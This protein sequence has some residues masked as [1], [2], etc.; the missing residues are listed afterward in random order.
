MNV[1][2]NPLLGVFVFPAVIAF[3][4]LTILKHSTREKPMNI[5]KNLSISLGYT[6]LFLIVG[7]IMAW[8]AIEVYLYVGGFFHH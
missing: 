7:W 3:F 1:L 4:F 6:L 8:I 5:R 2:T